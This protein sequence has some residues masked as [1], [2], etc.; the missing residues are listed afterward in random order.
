M[1]ILVELLLLGQLVSRSSL[2]ILIGYSQSLIQL[3]QTTTL[4]VNIK[5]SSRLKQ[6]TVIKVIEIDPLNG[7]SPRTV[8]RRIGSPIQKA[9]VSLIKRNHGRVGQVGP[10]DTWGSA[11]KS[12]ATCRASVISVAA[13]FDA[14]DW[15]QRWLIMVKN[16]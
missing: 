2:T 5:T 1:T 7:L 15:M 3:L 9:G 14:L 12:L 16:C 11:I 8:S 6:T 13:E 10:A 4:I